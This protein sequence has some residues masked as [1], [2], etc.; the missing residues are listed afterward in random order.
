MNRRTRGRRTGTAGKWRLSTR[1]MWK[2]TADC[3]TATM[4]SMM[5]SRLPWMNCTPRHISSNYTLDGGHVIIPESAVLRRGVQ[6]VPVLTANG[7]K[8]VHVKA[9]EKVVFT[10]DAEVPDGAG[11]L[12]YVEWSFEGEQDFPEKGAWQLRDNGQRGTAEAVHIYEKKGTY[13]AVVRIKS[14]RNGDKAAPFTQIR[15]IDRVRV[16]V[17]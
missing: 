1:E 4:F 6:A 14:E 11:A 10:V 8:C 15:N 2:I 9:G 3:I 7:S 5:M 16:V 12:T 17:E 13:F